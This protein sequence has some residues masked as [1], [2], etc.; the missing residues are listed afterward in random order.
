MAEI[1]TKPTTASV[2]KFLDN[3]AGER[4]KDCDQIVKMMTKATG[5]K[6]VMWGDAIIGFGTYRLKYPDGREIDWM[7][8]GF[9]PRKADISLYLSPSATKFP[10]ILDRLGKHKT[11]KSCL[12]V[13]RLSDI[14]VD[15]LQQLFDTAATATSENG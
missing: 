12:Y 15:V 4:R 7:R 6:P 10:D 13:K 1:K 5:S 14:D 3:A 9:S 8:M 11:A 2:S